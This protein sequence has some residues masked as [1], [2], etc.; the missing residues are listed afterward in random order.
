MQGLRIEYTGRKHPVGELSKDVLSLLTFQDAQ[1]GY[2]GLD[3]KSYEWQSL[4]NLDIMTYC[5]GYV[6]WDYMSLFIQ[7]GPSMSFAANAMGEEFGPAQSS[8]HNNCR[9]LQRP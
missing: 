3:R 4:D 7:A 2:C 6:A 9:A 8:L 1:V 5:K